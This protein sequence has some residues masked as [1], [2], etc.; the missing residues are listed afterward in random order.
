VDFKTYIGEKALRD[1]IVCT[2]QKRGELWH[3]IDCIAEFLI[4]PCYTRDQRDRI[5]TWLSSTN[6]WRIT[7]HGDRIKAKGSLGSCQNAR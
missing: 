3:S 1:K 5:K 6:D 7:M 4:G 2:L